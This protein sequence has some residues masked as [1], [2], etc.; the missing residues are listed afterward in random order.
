MCIKSS[1]WR[2]FRRGLESRGGVSL[3][4]DI[5]NP[6][7]ENALPFTTSTTQRVKIA[8]LLRYVQSNVRKYPSF[9][10]ICNSF[11]DICNPTCENCLPFWIFAIPFTICA[12]SE[13]IFTSLGN[14]FAITKEI[15]KD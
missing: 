13:T 4:N 11:L 6:L 3:I 9:S 15:F 14:V 1:L 8:S 10:N 7:C 2:G 12:V 5:Y